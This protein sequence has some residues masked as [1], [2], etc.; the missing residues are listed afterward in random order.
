MGKTEQIKK[1]K[2]K[3]NK[4]END[5][6]KSGY[7]FISDKLLKETIKERHDILLSTQRINYLRRYKAIPESEIFDTI[8]TIE[9]KL[10]KLGYIS[11]SNQTIKKILKEEKNIILNLSKLKYLRFTFNPLKKVK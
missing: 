10:F 1:L 7:T 5:F 2:I 6:K 8:K 3:I 9:K 4:I 11:P